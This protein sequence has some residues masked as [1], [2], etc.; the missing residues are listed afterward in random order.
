[1]RIE[2][3]S[4]GEALEIYVSNDGE[5]VPK[6]I[7]E[8]LFSL[9]ISGRGGSGIGLYT[10]KEIVTAMDGEISFTGNDPTLGGAAFKIV[11]HS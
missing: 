1:M 4:I 11:F 8:Q 5:K 3:K 9:G 6:A 7:Q 2:M 10:C